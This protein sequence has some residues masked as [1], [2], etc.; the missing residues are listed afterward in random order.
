MPR[1]QVKVLFWCHHY[2]TLR[3]LDPHVIQYSNLI[4][5]WYT[6]PVFY[7]S[8]FNALVINY[9]DFLKT[10]LVGFDSARKVPYCWVFLHIWYVIACYSQKNLCFSVDSLLSKPSNAVLPLHKCYT[11]NTEVGAINHL[12]ITIHLKWLVKHNFQYSIKC[13]KCL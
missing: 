1:K 10:L 13:L 8:N 3:K 6:N 12:A 9:I 5:I 4:W 7:I 11:N 2:V